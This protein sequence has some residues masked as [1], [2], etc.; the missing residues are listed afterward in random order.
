MMKTF[1]VITALALLSTLIMLIPGSFAD[2]FVYM[3]PK[4]L[5]VSLGDGEYVFKE[6]VIYNKHNFTVN[7]TL[8]AVNLQCDCGGHGS[9]LIYGNLTIQQVIEIPANGSLT[10]QIKIFGSPGDFSPFGDDGG[11]YVQF[12]GNS[13]EYFQN[14]ITVHA[15]PKI[16]CLSSV[17]LLMIASIVT[18]ILV[19]KISRKKKNQK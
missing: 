16:P 1:R 13:S 9:L 2:E 5:E 18:I 15:G 7:G 11:F 12:E 19:V 14:W 3:E 10:F 4:H 17:L 6:F 8:T